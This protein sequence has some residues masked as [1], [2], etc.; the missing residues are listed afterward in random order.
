MPLHNNGEESDIREYVKR[1]KISGGT[2]SDDGQC[3]RD[4]FTSLKKTC[5][6]LGVNFR[7][8]LLDRIRGLAEIPRLADLIRQRAAESRAPHAQAV[9]A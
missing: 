4:T 1:R 9:P 3:C 6:K 2:R 5:R 8:Y 7:N